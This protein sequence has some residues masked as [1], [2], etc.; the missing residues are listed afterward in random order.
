M[1]VSYF[2]FYDNAQ[3]TSTTRKVL[4]WQQDDDAWVPVPTDF[5][6]TGATFP[7][8]DGVSFVKVTD[9]PLPPEKDVA[10]V[11][12]PDWRINPA[13][14]PSSTAIANANADLRPL[15][16]RR[17]IVV[18]MLDDL[19]QEAE[20]KTQTLSAKITSSVRKS[21]QTRID[22]LKALSAT[23]AASS[24]PESLTVPAAPGLGVAT[25]TEQG[26]VLE[27]GRART[28]W[29]DN[30]R[31]QDGLTSWVTGGTG[32]G[33]TATVLA[34]QAE[35]LG[36][37]GINYPTLRAFQ[38]TSASDGY[39]NIIVQ[40]TDIDGLNSVRTM[41][42][43][44]GQWVELSAQFSM[45][46]CAGL[47]YVQWFDS[48]AVSLGV[49]GSTA[50]P[51]GANSQTNPE[52]WPRLL[53]LAQAP[54]NAAFCRPIFRKNAT[55]AGQVDSYMFIH[56]PYLGIGHERQTQPSPFMAETP[57]F[58]PGSKLR[59]LSIIR[60]LIGANAVSDK[61]R[62]DNNGPYNHVNSLIP[63]TQA[64]PALSI[65]P[66]ARGELWLV[67]VS[68]EAKK[69]TNADPGFFVDYRFKEPGSGVF[70]AW[71]NQTS[72]NANDVTTVYETKWTW[73]MFGMTVDDL[74]VRVA[75]QGT[76]TGTTVP[77]LRNITLQAQK[78]VK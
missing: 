77:V 13:L 40:G 68:F 64:G 54:A 71:R 76:G 53:C 36:W 67:S 17:A 52:G 66:I 15:T 78:V 39:M 1:G 8:S 20:T 16:I 65:G 55:N 42:V 4:F 56:A 32:S 7:S 11:L 5:G 49:S 37:S 47:F 9:I 62:Q 12:D 46:R 6:F 30:A 50:I 74:E 29:I 22:D 60:G 58:L 24:N 48:A 57:R 69:G 44:P 45:H 43:A 61:L 73:G 23:A 28:N 14:A 33:L 59:N 72:W 70:T 38:N 35:N 25:A 2:V 63:V 26:E 10:G 41:P 21:W 19:V 75:Y 34:V 31:Y 3:Y 27:V 18:G 51:L